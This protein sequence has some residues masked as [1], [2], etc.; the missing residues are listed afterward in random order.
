DRPFHV[1]PSKQ[2]T[3]QGYVRSNGEVGIRN[4]IWVINTVGCV[5]KTCEILAKRGNAL[6]GDKIYGV[7]HFAHPFGCSQLGD[8]LK[9]TQKLLASLVHHPNAA[10]VLVVGLGCENNQIDL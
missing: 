10:G 7:Y 9:Y 4:E 6:Y 3:F 8:D 1:A 2:R 5:N